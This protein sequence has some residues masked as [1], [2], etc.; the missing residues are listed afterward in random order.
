MT[1]RSTTRQIVDY[2]HSD[3]LNLDLQRLTNFITGGSCLICRDIK[4]AFFR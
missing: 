3:N 1:F 2:R 4:R